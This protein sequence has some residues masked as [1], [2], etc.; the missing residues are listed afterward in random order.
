MPTIRGADKGSKKRYVG[1]LSDETGDFSLYFAGMESNRRDWTFLAKEFQVD[2][3]ELIFGFNDGPELM[4][5][6]RELIEDRCCRL[7]NGE[8]DD[9]LVYRKGISK[10]LNQY[11]K[12]IPPHVRAARMLDDFN[13]RTVQYVMTLKG[14]EPIQKRS[15]VPFDYNH[16]SEKQLA[17]VADMVPPF[18]QH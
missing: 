11:V 12:N 9:K 2:I 17:P 4:E 15:D 1:L 10:P 6:L 14:P 5:K 8:L 16:Y 3:F 18:F 7:F 13:D